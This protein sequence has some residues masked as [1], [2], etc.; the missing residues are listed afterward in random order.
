MNLNTFLL[1]NIKFGQED[2]RS[3]KEKAKRW[4]TNNRALN[5]LLLERIIDEMCPGTSKNSC[6]S[7]SEETFIKLKLFNIE[8]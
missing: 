2:N 5:L 1:S 6:L 3:Y 8:F 7:S 4:I